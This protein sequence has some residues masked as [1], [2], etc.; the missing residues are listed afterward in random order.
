MAFIKRSIDKMK[1][2]SKDVLWLGEIEYARLISMGVKDTKKIA[3]FDPSIHSANMGDHIIKFYCDKIIKELFSDRDIYRFPTQTLPRREEI[4]NLRKCYTGIVCGTNLMTPH[5]EEYS[6]WKMPSNLRDYT[7]IITLGVGWGYYCS[8]ISMYSKKVYNTILSSKGLHSVRDSYTEKRFREMGI[9][10]VINTGCPTLWNLTEEHCA[11]IPR[12]KASK[13][14]STVTDYD[15]NYEKDKEMLE[16]LLSQYQQVFIWL[17]GSN[18]YSYLKEIIDVDLVKIVSS[19]VDAFS[20]ILRK[21]DI[22]YVGTRLHAGIH[23]MNEKIRTLI[24]SIDNR[25][26]EMGRDFNLPIISRNCSVRDLIDR[27]NK[28]QRTDIC[29]NEN[30]IQIWKQQFLG[31]K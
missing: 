7:N 15:R 11:K 24:I 19:S 31:G 16:V 28:E 9:K 12:K 4:E 1:H 27:I 13:V 29:I 17:Q 18:D 8:D 22:D 10:N 5:F 21:G 6:N 20:E 30:K 14:I 25:A 3:V 23:A 26:E 2:L